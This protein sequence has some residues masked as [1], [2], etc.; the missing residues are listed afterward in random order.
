MLRKTLEVEMIYELSLNDREM[1]LDDKVYDFQNKIEALDE[2]LVR[3]GKIVE[4]RHILVSSNKQ[5]LQMQQRKITVDTQR[6][7][8]SRKIAL[9]NSSIRQK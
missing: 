8:L 1:K 4:E 6:E 5:L 2:K 3:L 7:D 9:S